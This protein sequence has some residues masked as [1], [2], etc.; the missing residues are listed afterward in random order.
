MVEYADAEAAVFGVTDRRN[1]AIFSGNRLT[2]APEKADISVFGAGRGDTLQGQVGHFIH[3]R[4]R[5]RGFILPK[6][7]KPFNLEFA[8]SFS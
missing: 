1:S 2:R 6:S 3:P 4:K 7:R 8:P 5:H